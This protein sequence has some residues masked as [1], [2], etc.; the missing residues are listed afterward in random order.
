MVTHLEKEGQKLEQLWVV[1]T[2][3]LF[4][5]PLFKI[6]IY[7]SLVA[8]WL[9][10]SIFVAKKSGYKISKGTIKI[11][12]ILIIPFIVQSI[13]FL[14]SDEKGEALY[15]LER[16]L[17]IPLIPIGFALGEHAF[18]KK[19]ALLFFVIFILSCFILN[20]YVLLYLIINGFFSRF[21]EDNLYNPIFRNAYTQLT[22]THLP[23]LGIWFL[24]SCIIIVYILQQEKLKS[25]YKIVLT[26]I[27]IELFVGTFLFSARMAIIAFCL[28][29]VASFILY[30][31]SIKRTLILLFLL[32][33]TLFLLSK[34]PT[35]SH[36]IDE[37]ANTSLHPP[38]GS[39]WDPQGINQYNS[40]NI[41]VGIIV[42]SLDILKE[43]WLV[44][45]GRSEVQ[46][47]LNKCYTRFPIEGYNDYKT[48][49]YNTHNQYI[50]F[51]LSSGLIGIILFLSFIF[52][53]FHRSF[54]SKDIF[55]FGFIMF[56][57][58]SFLTEN[59]LSRHSG[60]AFF[61][62]FSSFLFIRN[63]ILNTDLPSKGKL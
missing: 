48:V 37:I 12:L 25:Y 58:I 55:L 11:Y 4:A 33:F 28:T 30:F 42:C 22:N 17:S 24:F 61:A 50:D 46:S 18:K 38:T 6:P 63:F 14:I 57:S 36:R 45:V 32:T 44:G 9:I 34:I 20:S 26:L 5:F 43:N 2:A 19:H 13:G 60:V 21:S 39:P 27:G 62:L 29:L 53:I 49:D 23:Y 7:T 51:W 10:S 3:A 31:K 40:T 8:I 35:I 47:S 59:I 54:I 56:I 15:Y 52:Y 16:N 1:L 41:R